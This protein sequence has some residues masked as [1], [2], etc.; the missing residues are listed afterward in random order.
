[1]QLAKHIIVLSTLLLFL[2]QARLN[3]QCVNQVFSEETIQLKVELIETSAKKDVNGEFICSS[4]AL[5]K[6]YQQR[7][8][9]PAWTTKNGITSQSLILIETINNADLHGLNPEDYHL[10]KINTLRQELKEIQGKQSVLNQKMANLDL[11]L[12]DAYLLYASHIYLG[13][14]NPETTSPEWKAQ[15][16]TDTIK[17][18]EYL[19]NSLRSKTLQEDLKKLA[20]SQLEYVA[21]KKALVT[22]KTLQEKGGWELIPKG[23]KLESGMTD[24]RIEQLRKR[25]EVSNY[26]APVKENRSF[27]D[28]ELKGAVQTFQHNNGLISDGVVHL[29]TINSM[30]ISVEERIS[31]IKVNMERWRWLP[32]DL[33]ERH[34]RVNIANFELNLYDKGQITLNSKAIVGRIYR[35]TPVFSDTMTYLALNPYWTVPPGIL[36][37]DILPAVKKDVNY[38]ARKRIKVLDHNGN[39]VD[40][41]SIDWETTKGREY[42]FRQDPGRNNSLGLLKFMFPNTYSVYIHD[43]PSKGLFEKNERAFSSGCIRIQKP[44]ELAEYLLYQQD[45]WNRE[46]LKKLTAPSSKSLSVILKKTIPVHILYLTAWG[47]AGKQVQFRKDIYDRDSVIAIALSQGPPEQ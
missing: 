23:N 5:P 15:K 35:K 44:F 47:E 33:G 39:V 3:S 36:R 38:L 19:E 9:Q 7:N 18:D 46:K 11:I 1:M 12:T 22:L 42:T 2:S 8:F 16:R 30:N 28:E 45:D 21:L 4:A 10:R 26:I 34:V 24:E 31:Q 27:F 13:K 40:P 6:F 17:F 14:V 37:N 20:P 41:L 29:E 32:D 25:L 43:T